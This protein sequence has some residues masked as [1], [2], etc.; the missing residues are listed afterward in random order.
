LSDEQPKIT[1]SE[2]QKATLDKVIIDSIH[3]FM[4]R[5]ISRK[6]PKSRALDRSKRHK[7]SKTHI[8]RSTILLNILT[9]IQHL[10]ARPR[11]FRINLAE[12]EKDI[13]DSELSDILSS[14]VRQ[15]FLQNK[16]GKFCLPRGKPLS[17]IKKSGIADER[18]GAGSAYKVDILK[19]AIDEILKDSKS[20]QTIDDAIL[21][22]ETFFRFL[23]YSFEVGYIQ[24]KENENAFLNTM[25]PAIMKYGL[26][27]KRKKEELDGSYIYTR[28]LT[29][30]KIKLLAKGMAT[31]TM[32]QFKQDE[33]DILY[34]VAAMLS[35]FNVYGPKKGEKEE[36]KT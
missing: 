5:A 6:S 4:E 26:I 15:H 14:M 18:R 11:D 21:K 28:D 32:N 1:I 19:E 27:H 10:P 17:D 35:L 29:N 12:E 9:N 36:P 30:D 24:M 25:R 34:T 2:E 31:D 13:Q 22:S 20:R 23:R 3:I 33:K 16:R 7:Q 8:A